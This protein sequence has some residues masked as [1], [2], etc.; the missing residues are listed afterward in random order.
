MNALLTAIVLWL[1]VNFGLPASFDF[2]NIQRIPTAQ[3]GLQR[4]G[5]P[6][7][8]DSLGNGVTGGFDD[9]PKKQVTNSEELAGWKGS[10]R[11]ETA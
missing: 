2:P 8:H 4:Y 3:M 7:A 9:S 5:R 10:S 11:V 6:G 1:S